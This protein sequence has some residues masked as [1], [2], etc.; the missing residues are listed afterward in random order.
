MFTEN[1]ECNTVVEN[2]LIDNVQCQVE[3]KFKANFKSEKGT[4][5]VVKQTLTFR[6]HMP[7]AESAPMFGNLTF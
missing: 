2:N 1:Y 7:A 3:S 5:V 4:E 6:Q